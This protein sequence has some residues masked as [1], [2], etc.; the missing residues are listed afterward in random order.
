MRLAHRSQ[1]IPFVLAGVIL[2][3][4]GLAA[5][6][7]NSGGDVL[8]PWADVFGYSLLDAAVATA[9]YNTGMQSGNPDTPPP[10]RVPFDVLVGDTTI[11][12]GEFIYVP[13]YVADD[14]GGVPAGFPK[15]IYDQKADA[16]YLDDLVYEEY[17]VTA[18]FVEVDGKITVL[19]NDYIVGTKTPPLLDGTPAGTHYMVAATFCSP[20][21]PGE[22]TVELGGI[23]DGEP[24]VFLDYSV[25][26][27]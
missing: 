4:L 27:K 6:C 25:T 21:A 7:A 24:T 11:R 8:P 2:G 20:L 5:P 15:D 16:E 23:I 22:H 19:N 26:V 14:S 18:F 9:V 17:G 12:P 1:G 10:P 13:I 3:T